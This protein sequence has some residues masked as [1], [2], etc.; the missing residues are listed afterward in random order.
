MPGSAARWMWSRI[1]CQLE[2]ASAFARRAACPVIAFERTACDSDQT[3]RACC[4]MPLSVGA[5]TTP[6]RSRVCAGGGGA[7]RGAARER[8]LHPSAGLKPCAR[9]S[10]LRERA[11]VTRRAASPFPA[12]VIKRTACTPP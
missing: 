12:P 6:P 2:R 10:A 9:L 3:W 5:A 1:K 7:R 11:A 8:Q 4:T